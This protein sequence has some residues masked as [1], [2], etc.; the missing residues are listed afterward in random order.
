MNIANNKEIVNT[1]KAQNINEK[2]NKNY[3]LNNTEFIKYYKSDQKKG[4]NN[5]ELYK[6]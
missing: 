1:K 4:L 5:N 2:E 3:N 6:E